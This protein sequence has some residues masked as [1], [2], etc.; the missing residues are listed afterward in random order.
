MGARTGRALALLAVGALL[1]ACGSTSSGAGSGGNESGV[2][3]ATE[4]ADSIHALTGGRELN[5]TFSL[6]ASLADIAH[7]SAVEHDTPPPAA[8]DAMTQDRIR[9]SLQAPPGRTLSGFHPSA[10]SPTGAVALTFGDAHRD[11][12]AFEV[13]NGSLYGRI[14]LRYFTTLAGNPRSFARIQ[15]QVA[16]M[17]AFV[18]AAVNGQWVSLSA[19]TLKAMSGFDGYAAL[20]PF[21]RSVVPFAGALPPLRATMI[22]AVTPHLDAYVAGGALSKV[23]LDAGQFDTKHRISFPVVLTLSRQGRA[24]TAPRGAIPVN[25]AQ[26]GQLLGSVGA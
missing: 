15:R 9:L 19:A 12:F 21:I 16:T 17:P 3:P 14:D 13:I 25:L 23:V 2:A 22:P 8:Q 1:A 18:R 6:G 7:I 5:L 11:Y 10:G 24:I 4:L 20:R 26:I